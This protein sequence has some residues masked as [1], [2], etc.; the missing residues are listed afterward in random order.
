MMYYTATVMLY[1]EHYK[2]LNGVFY[3]ENPVY[4]SNLS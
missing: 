3:F 2:K 1:S 4:C